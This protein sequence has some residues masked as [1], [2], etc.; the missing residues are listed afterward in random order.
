MLLILLS[1]FFQ[2]ILKAEEMKDSKK[3]LI[4]VGISLNLPSELNSSS[5]YSLDKE[6]SI[7]LTSCFKEYN[8]R[9][10]KK[11][12]IVI[13]EYDN[14]GKD[15]RDADNTRK[16]IY[17][18]RVIA[19][20]GYSN[21][22]G[23]EKS[24]EFLNSKNILVPILFPFNSDKKFRDEKF[25]NIF[26]LRATVEEELDF[27]SKHLKNSKRISIIYLKGNKEQKEYFKSRLKGKK[28]VSECFYSQEPLKLN[29]SLLITKK[30]KPDT[31]VFIGDS[32]SGLNFAK[33]MVRTSLKDATFVTLSD[34]V[35]IQL[36]KDINEYKMKIISTNILFDDK[37]S[38]IKDEYSRSLKKFYIDAFPNNKSL[39]A[40]F[41]GKI[42]IKLL[43][44]LTD[45]G[46]ELTKENL[47]D[48]LKNIET[49]EVSNIKLLKEKN[50]F[51]VPM[52]LTKYNIEEEKREK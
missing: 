32:N 20:L 27:L 43:E 3:I 5:E 22:L 50:Y 42:L 47:I 34:V 26:T 18:D 6:Y 14:N 45:K 7:G 41:I 25:S 38:E 12:E 4:P 35:S 48:H 11:F 19:L 17:L 52:F 31:V 33:R 13:A 40:Y 9:E 51:K 10:D 44:E 49:I 2:V 1:L 21:S 28:I 46:K 29:K 8:S 15:T 39:E 30:A 36:L 23:I 37:E 16:L 24:C